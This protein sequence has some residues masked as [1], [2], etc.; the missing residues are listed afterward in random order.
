[1]SLFSI[2]STAAPAASA[3]VTES[4]VRFCTLVDIFSVRP[5]FLLMMALLYNVACF[6]QKFTVLL[7]RVI[8]FVRAFCLVLPSI[9]FLCTWLVILIMMPSMTH[10][11]C[12]FLVV[13]LSFP[14]IFLGELTF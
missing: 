14:A 13:G 9:C 4:E 1:M 10:S 6:A 11:Q 12:T 5:L 2:C 3:A 7:F 8:R